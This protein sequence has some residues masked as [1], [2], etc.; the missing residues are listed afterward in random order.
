M[1]VEREA[2]EA[3]IAQGNIRAQPH[4]A[5][6]LRILNYT[7]QV[8]YGRLW[9][10][11]TLMCRGLIITDDW[12]VV[13]RPFRKF[14][15]WGEWDETKQADYADRPKSVTE[16]LD[17][18]LGILYHWDGAWHVA[19]RGSFDSDQARV[20][21]QILTGYDLAEIPTAG[22]TPLVEI[23]YPSNR[24]VVDYGGVR[25]L[26]LLAALST[27]SGERL[28]SPW[29]YGPRAQPVREDIATLL[30]V[31]ES[32]REGFV[33]A[34]SDGEMAKIKIDE[35]VR[36]HRILTGTNA[37][38]V[39]EACQDEALYAALMDR[40][41]DEFYDWVRDTAAELRFR[42]DQIEKTA[43]GLFAELRPLADESRKAFALEAT[44]TDVADLL[45]A[46]L[47]DKAYAD[48]IWRRIK[49]E[50]TKPFVEDV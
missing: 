11:T 50:A 33:V 15:N 48:R 7:P 6:P 30:S 43:V 12:E 21:Q 19:T 39:W 18:S 9:D 4:P 17:G 3:H 20:A 40:V 25:E 24:I 42:Y 37:V 5:Y 26:V 45:F 35:Y 8:Q 49:P 38:R 10:D 13:A 1:S 36:L 2:V 46:M 47:D 14:F 44:K 16:K 28:A 34:F 29:W 31:D 23:I 27:A 22:V 41:P 32:N